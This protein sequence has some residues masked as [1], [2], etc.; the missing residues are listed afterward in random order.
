MS[1]AEEFKAAGNEALKKG[2]TNK[3]IE[4]YTKA[5]NADGSNHVYY[6]NRS[7]A[8]LKQ[9]DANNALE[10]A[11]ACIGLNPDF[12]KGYSR[13]G[14]ALHS[15]KRYNDSIAIYNEGL[16]KFPDD[17]GLKKGLADVQ[18]EKENPYGSP[19][20][21]GGGAPGGLFGPQMMAQMAMD[22]RLRK[23]LNDPDVMGKIQLVQKNPSLMPTIMNDPKMMEMLSM[24]MG[25][26]QPEEGGSSS[27]AS[28]P[29]KAAPKKEEKPVEKEEDWSNLS[30]EERKKKE[31]E[32]DAR[33][34]KEAGNEFYKKKEFEKALAAYDEAIAIDPTNMTFLSNKAAVYFTQKKYDE[35]IQLC[36][37]AV[38]VGKANMGP[39]EDRAKAL[40]RC[41]KAYQKKGDLAKAIEMCKDAQLENYD[42]ATQRLLKTI[43]L[44]KKK[45]DVSDYQDDAKAD[46]AKQRGND[47][48][49][50]KEWPKAVAE[51][52][53]AVK[54]APKNAAIRNNLS[55]AL[56]KIMDFNGA[57]REAEKALEIDP[58]YVKAW[59]RKGDIEMVMKEFHK[60][61]DSYKAG[62]ELDPSNAACKQGLQKV[63]A[64]INYGRASMTD[65]QKKEQAAHA[66]ADP[67]IQSILTDP[68]IQQVLRDF[69]ENPNAAQKA[70]ADASVAAKIQ[71]LIASGVVETR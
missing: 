12:A 28:A 42:K 14:A 62:L 9:G 29:K 2:D 40:T 60:A 69:A 46:E 63:T 26:E 59:A 20:G 41:A 38:E 34:K 25:G 53:E 51:Y 23:Y 47:F 67:E 50:S 65:E 10:D 56:C 68:V 55:A 44:E 48:F 70:M 37:E 15:L 32:R 24:M 57:R 8:Y 43:E 35:C 21:A 31:T 36:M 64:Q 13:K 3:A 17:A 6:S 7:A 30:P 18:R 45:K 49:R 19:G 11:N 33:V 61:M 39:F 58:K 5:I 22:P 71:K 1:T 52:E 16:G 27:S 66:M 54:R 4:N